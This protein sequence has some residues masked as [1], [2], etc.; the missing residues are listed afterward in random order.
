[1]FDNGSVK[2]FVQSL[3]SCEKTKQ[4]GTSKQI[5]ASLSGR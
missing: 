1:M 2:S 4:T 5:H 3:S